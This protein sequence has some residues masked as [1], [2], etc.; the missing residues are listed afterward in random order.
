MRWT[1]S[2]SRVCM[3]TAA[4][5]ERKLDPNKLP[6]QLATVRRAT[7]RNCRKSLGASGPLSVLSEKRALS[8]RK[9]PGEAANS[10]D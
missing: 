10:D 6:E 3:H 9:G 1:H 2:I 7:E 5:G 8:P 4:R